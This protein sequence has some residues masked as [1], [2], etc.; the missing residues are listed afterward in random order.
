MMNE[1][2]PVV[3]CVDDDPDMLAWMDLALSDQG[4]EIRTESDAS[5]ALALIRREPPDLILLDVAM[6]VMDG[7]QVC[8]QLQAS[9]QTSYVPVVFVTGLAGQW[10]R[11]RAFLVGAVDYLV[12][13][14]T[15]EG[16]VRAVKQ[17]LGTRQRFSE[18]RQIASM[19]VPRDTATRTDAP[20]RWDARLL[21]G[22]FAR[23]KDF[24][25]GRLALPADRAKGLARLTPAALYSGT[26]ELGIAA[27]AV[28]EAMAAFLS[29]PY[30]AKID[31]KQVRLGVLP[32]P[33]C[34]SNQVVAL[35]GGEGGPAFALGNPFHWEVLEA[36]R[37]TT[38]A[39]SVPR[40]S[41]A[42]PAAFE[43]L[44]GG[45]APAPTAT[46]PVP[47]AAPKGP[48]MAA[49]RAELDKEF[50]AQKLATEASAGTSDDAGPVVE[51]VNHLIEAAFEAGASDI[52]VEPTEEDLAIRYRID[53]DLHVV[54]RLKPKEV[55]RRIIARLKVMSQ[56]DIA[57]HRLPQ[58]GRIC[59]KPF[60]RKG[61]DF[62]LRVA[63]A[64]VNHG[65]KAVLRILDKQKSVLP[66][67]A[68]GF[69]PRNLEIY[70]ERIRAP[71]GMVL[72]VGPTGSGKSM[73]LYAALN[74]IK[75]PSVNIQTAEDPIEYTLPGI[76]Q[77]QVQPDI[78][79][80][81]SRALRSFLRMDPDI[82][83]VGE[84]R[85]QETAKMAIEASLTGHL[86]LSTLH[87]NDS[88]STV[89]RFIEMGIEPYLV[90]SSLVLV[91]AQRLLRRLCPECREAYAPDADERRVMG[92]RR[93]EELTLYRPRGCGRCR[94]IGYRGRIAVHE[95]LAPDDRMRAAMNRKGASS[96][97][98]KRLAVLDGMSTLFRDA[99]DKVRQGTCSLTDA[100]QNVRRDELDAPADPV[101]RRAV[102]T[103]ETAA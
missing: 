8:E 82:V 22:G 34:L 33:F 86:L 4:Y 59:F 32:T 29:I 36:V 51:L 79:L 99:M 68:L 50:A 65:E 94:N 75:D 74:E 66:L 44:R 54:D 100:L 72:H 39:G 60:S 17:H 96:D 78:G 47:A 55:G 16:V 67:E 73:S 13:P 53:G 25:A 21:S 28:A 20:G 26:A 64:P 102:G 37:R 88:A 5:K 11:S 103:S 42:E 85:D 38:T 7:Y 58:D 30:L 81:F 14:I 69:S 49:I 1:K 98:L 101:L 87:T 76:S 40:L 61:S 6:P 18:V 27:R 9:T 71:Y 23:F 41:V 62:D 12:K 35:E 57:E 84:I 91:C 90:S 46:A 15:E 70:R 95:I 31:P 48:S 45:T 56:L 52:H 24:L 77:L 10:E 93:D 92:A 19:P 80:T 97:E 89:T 3:F 2:K 63:V 83:L 43:P